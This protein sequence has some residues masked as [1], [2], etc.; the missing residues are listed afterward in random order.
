MACAH[1]KSIIASDHPEIHEL[2]QDGASAMLIPTGSP[3]KLQDA[4]YYLLTHPNLALKMAAKKF[5]LRE[6]VDNKHKFTK[7]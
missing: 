4:L 3:D 1:G 7:I 2:I 5:Q 6:K